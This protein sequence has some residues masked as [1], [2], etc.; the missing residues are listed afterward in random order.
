MS[1]PDNKRFKFDVFLSF[2]GTDTRRN[3]TDHLFAALTRKGIFA[4]R[5][6]EELERGEAISDQLLKAI[7]DSRSAVVVLSPNYASSPWCLDELVKIL[8]C[9]KAS[10][11]MVFPIFYNVEPSHVRYQKGSFEDAFKNFEDK[12]RID[13]ARLQK[14]REALKE[15]ADLSGFS[16]MNTHEA[17][18]I[19]DIVN[20][21][22]RILGNRFSGIPSELVGVEARLQIVE[23]ALDIKLDGS[24]SVGIA[25]MGGSG[26]TTLARVV[27][28]RML[29]LFDAG[30]FLSDVR[31]VSKNSVGLVNLQK[32][33]LRETIG[34]KEIKPYTK[35]DGVAIIRSRLQHRKILVVLDDVDDIEQASH[36][37]GDLSWFGPGS[38]IIITSR[39]KHLLNNVDYTYEVKL[40]DEGESLTLFRQFS[41]KKAP[42]GEEFESLS[43]KFCGYCSGLP[44]AL[45]VL[46]SFLTGRRVEEWVSTLE[47]LKD[48]PNMK[49]SDILKISYNGL[50][51]NQKKVFLYVACFFHGYMERN[52]AD[53]VRY[54]QYYPEINMS[55]LKE[56]SLIFNFNERVGMH[57]LLRELGKNIVLQ[58][59][60]AESG[61]QSLLWRLDDICNVLDDCTGT[62]AVEGLIL[63]VPVVE[64]QQHFLPENPNGLAKLTG[65]KLLM[66][67]GWDMTCSEESKFLSNRIRVLCWDNY[68]FG[69]LPSGFRPSNLHCLALTSG[70][71]RSL[72]GHNKIFAKLERLDLQYSKNLKDIPNLSNLPNL[73]FLI[74]EGCA[75][76]VEVCSS[77][78][79]HASITC[80][81]LKGCASLTRLPEILEFPNL[82]FLSLG[83]CS[84]LDSFPEISPPMGKLNYLYLD[85]TAI[86]ELPPSIG[87]LIGLLIFTAAN[88]HEL[89]TLPDTF[90]DLEYLEHVNLS[91]CRS[92]ERL[93]QNFGRLKRLREL[94]LD[95]KVIA[96]L[97]PNFE[98]PGLEYFRTEGCSNFERFGEICSGMEKLNYLHTDG[99]AVA[100]LP[101]SMK[102][103]VSQV[104]LFAQEGYPP[105]RLANTLLTWQLF[106]VA[107]RSRLPLPNPRPFKRLGTLNPGGTSH[108][109]VS[110]VVEP[111]PREAVRY[112]G[113]EDLFLRSRPRVKGVPTLSGGIENIRKLRP[114]EAGAEEIRRSAESHRNQ[115]ISVAGNLPAQLRRH[116]NRD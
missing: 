37:V 6:D 36:L 51:D 19:E 52:V 66:V 75:E 87:F 70:L 89:R 48:I 64:R 102:H 63:D 27:Y 47:E 99:I 90:S 11:M 80:I 30:S 34:K 101:S 94:H 58:E 57:D 59:S 98:F 85:G 97:P 9:K 96:E 18:F 82:E 93:P 44:L 50:N 104:A 115:L 21:L 13:T 107:G 110:R 111:T 1:S 113:M 20:R 42:A 54:L 40:L 65:L 109:G 106:G 14:W 26:K 22:F 24:R 17:T 39:D 49:I 56:R 74:L 46:G 84:R 76:L 69:L 68:P 55:V 108:S 7:E 28:E 45:K 105:E 35:E 114:N 73:K 92:L 41:F 32:Q 2:R 23:E 29:H 31:E 83:G 4:F 67:R 12:Q 10:E 116:N 88:C 25:G 95:E 53:L 8:E 81:N 15:V 91:G 38:R 77:G 71:V 100:E 62:E 86:S 72:Q 79:H 61:R 3:F 112:Q 60:K 5:D 16:S 33:L 43:L 103:L 78:P